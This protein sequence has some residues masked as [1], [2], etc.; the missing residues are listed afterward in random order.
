[1]TKLLLLAT[2]CACVVVAAVMARMAWI[3][4]VECDRGDYP[5]I[6]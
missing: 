4:L 3:E 2:T 1:M 6:D 5:Q